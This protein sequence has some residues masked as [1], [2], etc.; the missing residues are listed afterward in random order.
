MPTP[1]LPEYRADI[2]RQ[3]EDELRSLFMRYDTKT[4][5]SLM[6][7]RSASAL[8]SLHTAGIWKVEDVQA[9]VQ[10]ALQNIYTPQENMPEVRPLN[11]GNQTL[12]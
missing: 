4:L 1:K 11:D 6:F 5:A 7:I 8:R 12:Q 2:L 10:F 3:C 9:V